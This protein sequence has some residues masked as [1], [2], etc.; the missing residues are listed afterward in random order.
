MKSL[1]KFSMFLLA[2]TAHFFNLRIGQAEFD[3]SEFQASQGYKVKLGIKKWEE[4]GRR[5][6]R[7]EV[8]RREELFTLEK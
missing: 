4:E 6:K 5:Q 1:L 8:G 7:E 3:G 2:M